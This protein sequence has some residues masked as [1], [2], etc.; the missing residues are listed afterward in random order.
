MDQG[1]QLA[2]RRLDLK[3]ARGLVPLP[4]PTTTCGHALLTGLPPVTKP[5]A[6]RAANYAEAVLLL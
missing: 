5:E 4:V 1:W 3:Y 2:Q 6:N